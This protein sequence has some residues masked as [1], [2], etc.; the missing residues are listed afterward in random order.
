LKLYLSQY[1]LSSEKKNGGQVLSD[2]QDTK[3]SLMN[4]LNK[5]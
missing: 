5:A 4:E 3:Q 2:Y 1:V